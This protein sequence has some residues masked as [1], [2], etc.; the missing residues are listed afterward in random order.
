M[1]VYL[2]VYIYVYTWKYTYIYIYIYIFVFRSTCIYSLTTSPDVCVSEFQPVYKRIYIHIC[3]YSIDIYM[4]R[5]K[6]I[7]LSL[8]KYTYNRQSGPALGVFIYY[9]FIMIILFSALIF[10]TEQGL[11]FITIESMFCF[12]Y[13]IFP[14]HE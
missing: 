6:H 14:S 2:E 9:A 8:C 12:I 3:I 5:N 11:F 13:Y 4:Y 7:N 1:Y 10:L